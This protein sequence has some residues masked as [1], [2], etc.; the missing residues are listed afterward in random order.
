MTTFKSQAISA[1]N[2]AS[3]SLR[4]RERR[5]LSKNLRMPFVF[6]AISFRAFQSDINKLCK[7]MQFK[8]FG[9]FG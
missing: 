6:L 5:S 4:S 7:L 9:F 2:A 3:A 8:L 1:S